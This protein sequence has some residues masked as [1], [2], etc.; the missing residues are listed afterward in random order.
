MAEQVARRRRLRWKIVV[1]LAVLLLAGLAT[2]AWAMN[3]TSAAA[4]SSAVRYRSVTVS[5]GSIAESVVASGTIEPAVTSDLSFGSSGEVTGVYVAQGQKVAKGQRLAT[6]S[7]ATLSSSVAQARANLASAV[8][9]LDS[10]TTAA[11]SAAQIASDQ[12]DI[13]VAQAQVTNAKTALAGATLVSPIDGTVTAVNITVGQQKGGST[14]SG[15]SG[16]NGSTSAGGTAGS[17]SGGSNSASSSSSSSTSSSS[18]DVEVISTGSYLVDATVDATDVANV[19]KGDQATI[20]PTGSINTVFGLV[21]SVGIVASSSSGTA[22]FPV[23]VSVT[24]SPT[25]LYAGGTADLAITYRQVSN[26][27][28]VPTLAVTRSAGS[29]YVTVT[30][31]G[32]NTKQTITTGISSGGSTEVLSGLADGDTVLVAIRTGTGTGTTSTPTAFAGITSTQP[33]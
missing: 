22:T 8:A 27:L 23:V 31:N 19:A 7:S 16:G 15:S 26:V 9:K 3:R 2:G 10:D 29:S 1:P 6:M 4:T 28:V 13:T 5:T 14:G 12:A 18:A 32:V 25:G 24:G 33:T 17:G 30:R 21:T 20:T 11:A